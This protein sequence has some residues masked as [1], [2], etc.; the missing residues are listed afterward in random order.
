MLFIS[1]SHCKTIIIRFIILD[2][3][4]MDFASRL[5][6]QRDQRAYYLRALAHRSEYK[7]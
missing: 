2:V 6:L 1:Q 3:L 5:V 7:P 4:L